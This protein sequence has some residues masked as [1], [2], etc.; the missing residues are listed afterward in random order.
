MVNWLDVALIIFLAGFVWRGYFTGLIKSVGSFA[1][2]IVGA[3][4][5]SYFYLQFYGLI[6][7]FFGGL[8]NIGH[9]ISFFIIFIIASKIIYLIFAALDKTYNFISIIPFLKSIN[10]LAGAALGL[11]IGALITSLLLYVAAKYLPLGAAFD[12]ALV[13]SKIAPWLLIIANAFLP[14]LSGGL[15]SLKTMI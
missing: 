7:Q 13:G 14:V 5:A 8:D 11:I 1:G 3:S 2:V 12:S 6:D 4:I 9:V 15:K 10:R